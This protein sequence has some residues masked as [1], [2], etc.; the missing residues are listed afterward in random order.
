MKWDLLVLSCGEGGLEGDHRGKPGRRQVTI[1]SEDSWADVCEELGKELPWTT[2]EANLLIR[3]LK[4]SEDNV[5]K[6]IKVGDVA[7]VVNMETK[8]T[9]MMEKACAGLKD[10]MTPEWRGGVCCRVL[11][12]GTI[13]IG[14]EIV[15]K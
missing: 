15:A 7:L 6:I 2:R 11:T 3:G 9:D 1:L 8:P 13:S 12:P 14:D 5:G 10:A 4:F